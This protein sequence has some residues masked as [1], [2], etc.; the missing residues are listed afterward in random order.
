MR[1]LTKYFWTPPDHSSKSMKWQINGHRKIK[2][3]PRS[4]TAKTS[5]LNLESL[6][7]VIRVVSNSKI[8][9]TSN[10]PPRFSVAPSDRWLWN[11]NGPGQ[12]HGYIC[13]YAH[14]TST[15]CGVV[16]YRIEVMTPNQTILHNCWLKKLINTSFTIVNIFL[17]CS[18]T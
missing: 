12:I 7:E 6:P 1:P 2:I 15:Q 8:M 10:L 17:N 5:H 18:Y 14:P 13:F 9:K 4:D 16:L 11:Y 3:L